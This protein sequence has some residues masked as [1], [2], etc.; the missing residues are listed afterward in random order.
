MSSGFTTAP[1]HSA[2]V[3]APGRCTNR[4]Q[5]AAG[6][7][8]EDLKCIYY[9]ALAHASAVKVFRQLVPDGVIAMTNAIGM[10]VPYNTS[11]PDDVAAAERN[12]VRCRL[13]CGLHEARGS[14]C[15][16]S[17]QGEGG[18]KANRRGRSCHHLSG[19]EWCASCAMTTVMLGQ[20]CPARRHRRVTVASGHAHACSRLRRLPAN[21]DLP[22]A[23]P[24]RPLAVA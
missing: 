8:G 17:R 14:R 9:S 19:D 2:G 1:P 24:C 18:K 21:P 6:E 7:D 12:Q 15:V 3:H 13:S 22:S 5:C 4:S 23:K 10:S 20:P 11:S 16:R